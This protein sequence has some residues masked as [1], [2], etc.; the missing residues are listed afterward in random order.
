M[1]TLKEQ[2][3]QLA[4]DMNAAAYRER[5]LVDDLSKQI[6][7]ADDNII[8]QLDSLIESH[9]VNRGLIQER[10]QVLAER[11]GRLPPPIQA[12]PLQPPGVPGIEDRYSLPRIVMGD[13]PPELLRKEVR[14]YA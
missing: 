14:K 3:D 5:T 10:I 1:K 6:T 4:A 9:S 8:T 13:T 12:Q 11:V 7:R 2:I